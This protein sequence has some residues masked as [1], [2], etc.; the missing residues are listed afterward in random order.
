MAAVLHIV[1]ANPARA[2]DVIGAQ[3]AAGDTVTVAVLGP[4]S[5][6]LPT[7]VIAHRVPAELSYDQLLTLVFS[8]DHVISW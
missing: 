3:V 1:G 7:G 6:V 2:L 5:P 4:E 8:V